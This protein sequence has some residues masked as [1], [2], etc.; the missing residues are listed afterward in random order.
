MDGRLVL[1]FAPALVAA[2]WAV[3][4]VGRVLLQQLRKTMGN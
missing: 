2:S 4:N 3:Y 1:V